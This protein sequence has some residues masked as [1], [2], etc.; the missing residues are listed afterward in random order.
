MKNIS[1][2]FF[3]AFF[4]LTVKC[5]HL[6]NNDRIA[7]SSINYRISINKEP[8][9]FQI[10]R[11]RDTLLTSDSQ[12]FFI[13]FSGEPEAIDQFI[14]SKKIK[15]T[16]IFTVKTVNNVKAEVVFRCYPD[17]VGVTV[18][19]DTG[20]I[21]EKMGCNLALDNN[22][23]WY[24]GEV[25][26]GHHWPLEKASFYRE[27]YSTNRNQT[28][29]VW[30]SSK[31]AGI[32]IN[33]Y[34]MTG[35][36]FNKP[37]NKAFQFFIHDSRSFSFI[38]LVS[39]N[40]AGEYKIFMKLNGIPQKIPKKEYFSFPVFNTW[41]EYLTNVTQADV[42]DY[43]RNIRKN[44]FPCKMIIIDDGWQSNYGD[45]SFNKDKFHDPIA[46]I[47]TIHSLGFNLMLWDIP[48]IDPRAKNFK[49][50]R[51]KGYLCIDK[52]TDEP[53]LIE[54]WHDPVAPIDLSNP[55]A[56]EWYRDELTGMMKNY[57]IDGFKL[58]AGDGRYLKPNFKTFGN[59]SETKYTDLF[60]ELGKSFDINE[61][62][63]GWLAQRLGIVQRLRDKYPGWG[64]GDSTGVNGGMGTVIA[65]GLTLSLLGYPYWAPDMIGGGLDVAFK[66]PGFVMNQ[67][68]MARWSQVVA[69]MP[70]MQFSYA[71]WRLNEQYLNICR[72]SAMLHLKFG[73][74]IYAQAQISHETGLPI[75]KPLFFNYPDE[76]E[77]Y[78]IDDQFMLGDDYLIAP[79]MT[80]GANKRNIY[81]PSGKW[82]YYEGDKIYEGKKWIKDFPSD[83]N[84]LPV[85]QRLK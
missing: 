51:D 45:H 7:Y 46:M 16:L 83:I 2:V 35:Y 38:I 60:L 42:I 26:M 28:A 48:M 54:W 17:Y 37:I 57:G 79:V 55:K 53:G 18:Q 6:F 39:E 64:T 25:V 68:L 4:L 20:N 19:C 24:G 34:K 74:Y 11:D 14:S 81:L 73:D 49:T 23:H 77:T 5:T 41:I 69:L 22:H 71:P 58:D 63:V 82:K 85:F 36:G 67:E 40:I 9:G 10:L 15:D 80:R 62:K 8:F 27:L 12:C 56:F 43:A 59:I 72:K 65:Q 66:E 31:G 47:D 50:A 3:V 1:I 44:N 84:T 75:I 32:F 78:Y 33:T 29:P 30:Y 21:P 13:N 61:F 70:I 52:N 76:Q